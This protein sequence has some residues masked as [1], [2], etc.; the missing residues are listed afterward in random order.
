MVFFLE[1]KSESDK[2]YLQSHR[3]LSPQSQNACFDTH[4]R[5]ALRLRFLS[6]AVQSTTRM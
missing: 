5:K 6:D 3:D 4:W 1:K 2:R